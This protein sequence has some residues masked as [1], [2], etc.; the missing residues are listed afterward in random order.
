MRIRKLKY[1][2][3]VTLQF[4]CF[5]FFLRT[6]KKRVACERQLRKSDFND[7]SYLRLLQSTNLIDDLKMF[8]NPLITATIRV[9]IFIEHRRNR[10]IALF[11]VI[12]SIQF[13]SIIRTWNVSNQFLIRIIDV[14]NL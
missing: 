1:Q 10:K 7:K 3:F 14:E 9:V 4:N 11:F 8:N 6:N 5:S 13:R 12:I 2:G